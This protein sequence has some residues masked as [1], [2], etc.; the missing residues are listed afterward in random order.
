MRELWGPVDAVHQSGSAFL[1]IELFR[2]QHSVCGRLYNPQ[3]TPCDRMIYSDTPSSVHGEGPWVGD[4]A[5][6]GHAGPRA[7][8]GYCV[9]GPIGLIPN[10][11]MESLIMWS[12][13]M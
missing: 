1:C 6:T 3:A 4:A 10:A 9:K 8:A 2:P 13:N 7:G 11:D 5:C 12:E